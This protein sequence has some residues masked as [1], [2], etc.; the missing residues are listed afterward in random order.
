MSEA[1]F[2]QEFLCDFQAACDNV[3]S[4]I[5]LT[6][7]AARR[8]VTARQVAGAPRVVGVDVARFGDDR[9]V[10]FRRHGLL[11][12]P[13]DTMTGIDNMEVAGRVARVIAEWKPDAVFVDAGRGEGVIDRLRQLGHAVI[14][15]P[16]GGRPASAADANKRSEMWDALRAWLEAGGAIPAMPELKS[17]LSAVT[18]AFDAAGRMVLEPKDKIKERGLRSPDLADALA[19][20]FAHPVAPRG[21]NL[22]TAFAA[23]E[24]RPLE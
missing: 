9:S 11:A 8:V 24:Y 6:A 23:A 22:A 5:D 19:L 14:E 16:F 18:Y 12:L 21:A 17:E 20:T 10:V 3:L 1:Q 4:P 7:A 15:G 2:R 13:P